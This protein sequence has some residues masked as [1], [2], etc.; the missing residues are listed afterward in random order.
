[1][2]QA[3]APSPAPPGDDSRPLPPHLGFVAG[4]L[5]GAADSVPGVSGGTIA[6]IL[7]VYER[8]ITAIS[9]VLRTP[10]LLRLRAGRRRLAAALRFLLPLLV[11]L[12]LAYYV[13]TLLLVGPQERPGWLR[14]PETAPLCYAFFFG[15]V[16]ASLREP[17][18]R[19][20]A[21]HARHVLAAALAAVAAAAF[22]GLPHAQGEPPTWA[23]LYGGA[24][25]VSV[26]LLPGISGSLLLVVLGQYTT[27]AGAIHDRE[28][29][30]LAV[31]AI[32]IVLGLGIFV[33]LL[34]RLLRRHH[35]VTMAALTGLMAGSLRALWPWKTNYDPK[36]GPLANADVG[37]DVGLV[38]LA[39]VAG[40][41]AA[42]GLARLERRMN[43]R[44]AG[45]APRPR[46]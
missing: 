1:M 33:P 39:L 41:L 42:W 13:G 37:G 8:F 24:L 6:L 23:L 40:A 28:I 20:Q 5:M 9:R 35:D 18:R 7:G 17:W 16:L 27:V 15:L 34:R 14:R 46:T 31:F 12:A 36:A 30:P 29:A 19:I 44:V 2:T 11:G 10:F 25:A 3:P 4:F 21:K 43:P 45:T 38:L 22:I 32:G 26:M